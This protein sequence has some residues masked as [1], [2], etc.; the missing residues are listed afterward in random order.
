MDSEITKVIKKDILQN[1]SKDVISISNKERLYKLRDLIDEKLDDII[2]SC[3]E[4]KE[5]VK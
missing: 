5:K 1:V 3:K 2:E 4:K